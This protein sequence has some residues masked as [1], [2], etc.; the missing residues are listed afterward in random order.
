MAFGTGSWLMR[1]PGVVNSRP[2]V[3]TVPVN[4]VVAPP[5]Q[6]G[7]SALQSEP[8]QLGTP[9]TQLWMPVVALDKQ[10]LFV[11]HIPVQLV[12]VSAHVS[13]QQLMA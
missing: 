9:I 1:V 6:V 7:G 12:A 2:G 3:R 4:L 11:A 13:T 8:V 10:A 5:E